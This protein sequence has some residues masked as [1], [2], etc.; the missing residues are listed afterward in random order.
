VE[1]ELAAGGGG[2]DLLSQALEADPPLSE[3]R[4]DFDQVLQRPPQAI[5]P[6]DDEGIPFP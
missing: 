4:H 2:V 3:L 1:D 6:P 5:E